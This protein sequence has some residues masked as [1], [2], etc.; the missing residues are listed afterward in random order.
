MSYE[1]KTVEMPARPYA[2]IRR[3]VPQDQIADACAASFGATWNWCD[4]NGIE[5]DGMPIN[6]YHHVDHAAGQYDIQPSFFLTSAAQGSGDIDVSETTPGDV[7]TL[8]HT[9]PYDGLGDAWAAIFAHAEQNGL[10]P[11]GSP[12]EQYVDDPGAVAP[13]ALRTQLYLP[14]SG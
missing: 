1:V 5:R 12:W 6:V 11:S 10:A 13:E 7:L 3:V 4:E 8:T 9:G 14:V 2:G